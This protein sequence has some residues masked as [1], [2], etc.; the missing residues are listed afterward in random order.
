[1]QIFK[2]TILIDFIYFLKN[3]LRF[4]SKTRINYNFLKITVKLLE[5]LL[6]ELSVANY[7]KINQ[8]F[9][10]LTEFIQVY[11]NIFNNF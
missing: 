11:R 8:C 10:T 4:Q 5:S 1:M 3:F 2:Y 7:Y 6:S 9:D